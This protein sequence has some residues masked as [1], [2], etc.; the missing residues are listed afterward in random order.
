[1][2]DLEKL[3]EG[4]NRYLLVACLTLFAGL[5]FFDPIIFSALNR[6]GESSKSQA[7][8][9]LIFNITYVLFPVFISALIVHGSWKFLKELNKWHLILFVYFILYV[10]I[11]FLSIYYNHNNHFSKASIALDIATFFAILYFLI[12]TVLSVYSSNSK[13]FKRHVWSLIAPLTGVLIAFAIWLCLSYRINSSDNIQNYR[14]TFSSLDILKV[15]EDSIDSSEK[16]LLTELILLNRNSKNAD[17]VRQKKNILAANRLDEYI[18]AKKVANLFNKL[19]DSIRTKKIFLHLLAIGICL[20]ILSHLFREKNPNDTIS[21]KG[22]VRLIGWTYFISLLL[23]L[24]PISVTHITIKEPNFMYQA[25]S[26]YAPGAISEII[27]GDSYGTS[28]NNT[29]QFYIS[30]GIDL[31]VEYPETSTDYTN[32]IEAIDSTLKVINDSLGKIGDAIKGDSTKG[33][34]DKLYNTE[35]NNKNE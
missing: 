32:A 4:N 14:N 6:W 5:S 24:K 31:K 16:A 15:K 12:S 20:M 13:S 23:L 26:W 22:W 2:F 8:L 17:N 10:F 34:V 9:Y 1:M 35:F 21:V 11:S 28:P 3:G 33:K 29:E 7:D 18:E 30:L 27:V 25:S 19:L